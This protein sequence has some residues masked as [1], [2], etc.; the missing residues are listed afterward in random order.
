MIMYSKE[1]A[2]NSHHQRIPTVSMNSVDSL[3]NSILQPET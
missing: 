2:Q 3:K 1:L